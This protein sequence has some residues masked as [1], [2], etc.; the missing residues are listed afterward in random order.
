VN[1]A[2]QASKIRTEEHV[3]VVRLKKHFKPDTTAQIYW[4][5]NR[6]PDQWRDVTQFDP[7]PETIEQQTYRGEA[8]LEELKKAGFVWLEGEYTIAGEEDKSSPPRLGPV[9]S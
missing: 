9:S 4:L 2:R 5:K 1:G 3:E 7:G 8:V 6:R